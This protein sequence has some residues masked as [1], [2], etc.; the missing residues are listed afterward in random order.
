[1]NSRL[2]KL[3]R[4]C[5]ILPTE[6]PGGQRL[7]IGRIHSVN[8]PL[9]RIT[10]IPVAKACTLQTMSEFEIFTELPEW[11]PSTLHFLM[12]IVVGNNNFIKTDI[13]TDNYDVK[14]YIYAIV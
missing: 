14:Y 12:K 5:P 13:S 1:M 10:F 2:F 9:K 4:L 11:L 8:L 3:I 6:R 7:I